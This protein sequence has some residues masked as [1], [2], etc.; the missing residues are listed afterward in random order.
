MENWGD[1]CEVAKVK[2][3]RVLD[4][5][6]GEVGGGQRDLVW[7]SSTEARLG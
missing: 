2:R 6:V 4:D 1:C 3:V 7:R 5:G